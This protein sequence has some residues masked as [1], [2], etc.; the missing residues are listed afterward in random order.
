M[1]WLPGDNRSQLEQTKPRADPARRSA[2]GRIGL[3][4]T[5][6]FSISHT[7]ERIG[8]NS[9]IWACLDS[10]V[11]GGDILGRKVAGEVFLRALLAADPFGAYHFFLESEA[12]S[13]FLQAWIAEH[14]P[15]VTERG[16]ALFL[17]RHAL[18]AAL[19][20]HNYF[21]FHLSDCLTHAAGLE[22]A[23]NRFSRR[24]FPITGTTHSLSYARY[25]PVF[26]GRLWPGASPKD[27]ITATSRCAVAVIEAAFASLRR[28]YGLSTEAFPAPRICRI[29][30]SA[31]KP[32]P[33]AP[34]AV[35]AFRQDLDLGDA[36][37]ILCLGRFSPHSKMDLL[38]ALAALRRAHGLGLPRET[39]LLA[40][41]W[42]EADDPL[43]RALE[44]YAAGLKVRF[45]ALLRPSAADCR[46]LYSAA[47][48]FLSP[49]DN[50]QE[51]FGLSVAEAASYGLPAVVSDFDGYRDI[52]EHER[53]GL[54]IP[55]LGF[56]DTSETNV[57]ARGIWFDNQYHLKLA[58]QV[59]LDVPALAAAL[60]RLGADPLLRVRLGTAAK[61]RYEAEFTPDRLIERHLALW[62]ELDA[63]PLAPEHESR[64]R[65]AVHPLGMDFAELFAGH[66]SRRLTHEV[67]DNLIIQRTAAGEALYQGLLPPLLYAG[68]DLMLDRD[69]LRR[70]L[71]ACRKPV[72]AAALLR[73]DSPAEAE[74]AAFHLLWA[75]KHDYLEILG[76]AEPPQAPPPK[77]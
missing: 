49:S 60:A 16:A 69:L 11:E 5:G 32:E 70:L 58:Q 13:N 29:P 40:A 15:A 23:R 12:Q 64:L 53:T 61:A 1:Q 52:V 72:N 50:I 76:E 66:C 67:S 33:A 17:P 10:F 62:E 42:A 75:L 73:P 26:L 59:S 3:T 37:L 77:G 8:K 41:G 28:S 56:A 48:I 35:A 68:M 24:I 25:M 43:P 36:P 20:A 63:L 74:R 31:P 18:P 44:A 21:C 30:L 51:T 27:A 9:R 47:D 7:M 45:R 6:T 57:L 38:P 54:L 34:E 2:S 4:F 55:S 14:F 22:W 71:L 39:L 65:A 46:L 19:A